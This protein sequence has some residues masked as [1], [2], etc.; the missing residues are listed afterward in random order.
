MDWFKQPP[1]PPTPDLVWNTVQTISNET[2]QTWFKDLMRAKK[3]PLT[4]D[5]LMATLID[6]SNYAMNR[7]KIDNLTQ[8]VLLGPVYNLLKGSEERKYTTSITKTKAARYELKFIEDMIPNQW[9]PITFSL[10]D[11]YSKLRILSVVS[12][13]VEKLHG[14]GFLKE[15]V[16]RRADRMLYKMK[17][18][19]FPNLHLNNIEDMLLLQVRRKL[20]NLE[21]SDLV[22]FAV[23]LRMFTRRIIIQKC[24]EDVQLGVE[25][26]QKKLNLTRPQQVYPNIDTKEP[27]NIAFNPLERVLN[28]KMG[29]NEGMP[30]RKWSVTDQRWSNII[31]DMIDELL[32]E[33][34]VM[35]NLERLVSARKLKMD[36]RLMESII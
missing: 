31:V 6:F 21:G 26:Y 15:I 4:F 20:F 12:V 24:V 34:Q 23:A 10:H 32:W 19:D 27:Y 8:D 7:L 13:K 16:V 28:F 11:V 17:Q 2:E 5:E 3:P 22:D 9:S 30:R 18:G 33:R 36:Y 14:Y 29:Y 35:R 25:S 1:K